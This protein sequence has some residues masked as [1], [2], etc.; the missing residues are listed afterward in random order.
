MIEKLGGEIAICD[1][2]RDQFY[3]SI[4]SSDDGYLVAWQ[5]DRDSGDF[6]VVFR[7]LDN[8]AKFLG[9]EITLAQHQGGTHEHVVVNCL[10]SLGWLIAWEWRNPTNERWEVQMQ[11]LDQ[12]GAPRSEVITAHP[13]GVN[14]HLR[15]VIK[16]LPDNNFVVVWHS[17]SFSGSDFDVFIRRFNRDGI[18]VA[19]PVRANNYTHSHQM[20]ASVEVHPEKEELML[21]WQSLG[22]DLSM[23]G[24][25]AQRFDFDLE[26][27]GHEMKINA[28]TE[29]E[30]TNP[31]VC[32]LSDGRYEFVWQ[33]HGVCGDFYSIQSRS[34]DLDS[35]LM[36]PETTISVGSEI[37]CHFPDVRGFSSGDRLYI[38][39]SAE[40]SDESMGIYSCC[41]VA[42]S[43]AYTPWVSVNTHEEAEQE[44]AAMAMSVRDEAMVVWQSEQDVDGSYGIYAQRLHCAS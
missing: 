16:V 26:R 42:A 6:E 34:F 5:S 44:N 13:R 29:S 15:P 35:G 4:A 28:I 39:Q 18:A 24:V 12:N 1:S 38:W 10:P 8:D 14:D 11:L 40:D 20:N 43:Q 21:V 41:Y 3:P 30:Q 33:S 27:V 31:K 19:D 9:P 22:Q 7:L 32:L 17:Y 36:S 23:Y 2:P 25:Y 37:S